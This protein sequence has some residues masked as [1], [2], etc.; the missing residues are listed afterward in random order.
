MSSIKHSP[1]PV[2]SVIAGSGSGVA[3]NGNSSFTSTSQ[4]IISRVWKG[5]IPVVFALDSNLFQLLLGQGPAGAGSYDSSSTPNEG[6]PSLSSNNRTP[7]TGSDNGTGLKS[8]GGNA[9]STTKAK[10]KD[11][12]YDVNHMSS[13]D[14]TFNTI[15]QFQ[16]VK[17]HTVLNRNRYMHY[18][19]ATVLKFFKPI[20]K[21]VAERLHQRNEYNKSNSKLNDLD[22]L[23]SSSPVSGVYGKKVGNIKSKSKYGNKHQGDDGDEYDDAR[24][25]PMVKYTL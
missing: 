15:K 23:V 5:T 3:G 24:D 7:L 1:S 8:E 4:Q 10:G 18:E 19:L 6:G 13:D 25:V 20:L 16:Q 11:D 14:D 21:Q 2:P 22:T 12:K 17:F 9:S